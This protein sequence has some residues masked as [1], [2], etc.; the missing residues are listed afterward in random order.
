MTRRGWVV[1]AAVLAAAWG[2]ARGLMWALDRL[3]EDEQ[4]AGDP[5]P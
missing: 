1:A 3:D 2:V 5:A 4:P